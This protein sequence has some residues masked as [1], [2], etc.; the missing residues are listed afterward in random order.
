[1]TPRRVIV[2]DTDPQ[3]QYFN[4]NSWFLDNGNLDDLGN[5]GA[6]FQHTTHSTS[7]NASSLSFRFKGSS[8]QVWGTNS[9]TNISGVLNPSWECFVDGVSIG[10]TP[11]SLEEENQFRFCGGDNIADGIHTLTVNV[12]LS[13][14]SEAFWFDYITYLPPASGPP[15]SATVLVSRIDPAIVYS[16][17][18]GTLSGYAS[19]TQTIGAQVTFNFTGTSLSWVGYIPR[20]LAILPTGATYSIDGGKP[21]LFR[22]G[23]LSDNTTALYNQVFFT[24][25]N[26]SPGP[27]S[28]VVIHQGDNTKTPLTLNYLSVANASSP[29]TSSRPAVSSTTTD[30]NKSHHI[31]IGAIVGGVI[32][33]IAA[34]C[35]AAYLLW[36]RNHQS[37]LGGYKRFDIDPDDSAKPTHITPFSA[38]SSGSTMTEASTRISKG[39]YTAV[40][41][42]P[43]NLD[44]LP[45]GPSGTGNT[46]ATPPT[47]NSENPPNRRKVP[48]RTPP[49]PV[50]HEDS[51]AR[52]VTDDVVDLPPRYTS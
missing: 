44:S 46:S 8:P 24:T 6:P 7:V 37:R 34:L 2:D 21:Q 33:G 25:P 45:S 27:H 29:S 16:M 19:F 47:Q 18:W 48:P 13:R 38:I 40:A 12:T 51:G 10:S 4:S 22:L 11:P 1:M 42:P 20:D 41:N 28:L 9:V 43:E 36:R 35:L 5:A 52:D 17:G 50:V 26:L 31:P 15:E 23:G 3:I 32:G 14:K 49:I 39:N 30:S